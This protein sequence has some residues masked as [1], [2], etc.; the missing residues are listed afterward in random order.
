MKICHLTLNL[1]SILIDKD[2][3]IK[4]INFKYGCIYAKPIE[5]FKCHDDMNIYNC[6]EIHAKQKFNPELADVYSCGIL[7]YYLYTG[8]LPFKSNIKIIND[9]FI[10]KGEYSLPENT[11]K[12][13]FKVITTLMENNP[14]KRKKFRD[15]LI[16]DWFN[17]ITTKSEERKELRG[18]NIFNEKYPIDENVIKICNEFKLN[19][20]DIVQNLNN[21]I[22]NS[23]TSLYK[24]IEHKLNNKGIK[25]LGDLH[26]DKFI[27]YLNNNTNHYDNKE[28]KK[29]H[30]NIKKEH[31]HNHEK[32]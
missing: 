27:G 9:E 5:K 21:N 1:D 20:K 6:P 23:I 19:K 16:E 28:S 25:T 22:F 18:F 14:E 26:S 24:Q 32:I 29:H 3:H 31:N 17:D 10:M 30:E 8:E 4:I 7:V 12:K 2:Y 15:L 11:S 13:M